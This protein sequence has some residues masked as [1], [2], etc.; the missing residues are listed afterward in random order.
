MQ[1]VMSFD[2]VQHSLN[3]LEAKRKDLEEQVECLRPI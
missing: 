1:E 3:A 2:T